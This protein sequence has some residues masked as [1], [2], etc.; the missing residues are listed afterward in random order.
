MAKY[1]LTFCCLYFLLNCKNEKKDI[2]HI[3][4]KRYYDSQGTLNGIVTHL[5]GTRIID[6]L[7]DV[8]DNNDSTLSAIFINFPNSRNLL[9]T[10][11]FDKQGKILDINERE[12]DET[13]YYYRD[14][15]PKYHDSLKRY[16]DSL[17]QYYTEKTKNW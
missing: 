5:D 9:L 16:S 14:F 4:H 10:L 15:N 3:E 13:V 11:T 8:N 1:I 7:Y 2:P 12:S 17:M 6:Y